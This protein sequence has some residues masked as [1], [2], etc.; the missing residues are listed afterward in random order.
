MLST[1]L[2]KSFFL[3]SCVLVKYRIQVLCQEQT[4]TQ[5]ELNQVNSL[6]TYL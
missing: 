3:L 1:G 6:L 5:L 2:V 4:V